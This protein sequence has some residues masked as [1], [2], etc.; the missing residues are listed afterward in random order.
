MSKVPKFSQG[1]DDITARPQHNVIDLRAVR[2]EKGPGVRLW[3]IRQKP[4][5]VARSQSGLNAR[6]ERDE[7]RF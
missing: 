7:P 5:S 1:A 3:I 6:P 2:P 4:V